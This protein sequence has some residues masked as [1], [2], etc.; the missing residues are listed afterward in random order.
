MRVREK[1]ILLFTWIALACLGFAGLMP[2]A[3]SSGV[4]M[5]GMF[6]GKSARFWHNSA[7]AVVRVPASRHRKQPAFA[8]PGTF[9]GP[10]RVHVLAV[11]ATERM[12]PTNM[13]LIVSPWAVD[14]AAIW[15]GPGYSVAEAGDFPNKIAGGLTS[16]SRGLFVIHQNLLSWFLDQ[17]SL[18]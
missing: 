8:I 12:V 10:V 15:I 2:H 13:T 4:A 6:L 17:E 14:Q 3:R 7:F 5:T 18:P 11:L 1:R 9:H 16:R